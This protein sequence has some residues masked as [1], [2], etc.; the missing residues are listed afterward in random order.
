MADGCSGAGDYCGSTAAL[1]DPNL[2]V[3]TV[4]LLEDGIHTPGSPAAIS[5]SGI[6]ICGTSRDKTI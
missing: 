3:D 4:L 1:T 2:S 5:L 6:K